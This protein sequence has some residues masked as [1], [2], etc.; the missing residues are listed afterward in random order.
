MYEK[1]NRI[2]VETRNKTYKHWDHEAEEEWFSQGTEIVREV[3]ASEEGTTLW[4]G[5]SEDQRA[6]WVK[7]TFHPKA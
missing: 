3:N 2:T 7:S 1:P 4:Q 5:W 6:A